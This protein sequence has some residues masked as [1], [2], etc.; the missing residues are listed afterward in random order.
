MVTG[1]SRW[2][3]ALL[4][5]TRRA[6]DL[7]AGWWHLISGLGAVPRTLVWD[8][9]GAVGRNR[10]GRVELTAECQGFRGVLGTKVIVLKPAEPEHKG[11]IERAHDYLETLVP[12]RPG[13]R[14]PRRLQHPAAGL[15]GP[16]QRPP[17][18]GAGLRADRP[19]RRGPGRD[20]AAAAGGSGHRVADLDPAGTRPLRAAGLQRLLGPSRRDRPP[21]RGGRRPGPGQGVQRRE[22]R[23]RPST[24]LGLAPDPDRPR[25]P[26][27]RQGAAPH[28][29]RGAAPGPRPGARARRS[30]SGRWPTTTPRSASIPT[31]SSHH[32]RT[33]RALHRRVVGNRSGPDRR[34]RLPDPGVE[35]AHPARGGA[36]AGRTRPRRSPGP[37]RSS[38][39]PACNARSPPG[40]PTAGRA[41]SAPP[42]SPRGSRLEEF[43]F[44]HA[45][46]TQTRH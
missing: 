8:G 11:I 24:G 2:L 20:A 9:E 34:G 32:D 14:R 36:P 3:S 31:A 39:S 40:S 37:T 6:E 17:P 30:S 16:G 43:D 18:A 23:G 33:A 25:P 41:G 21:D 10:R 45:R 29:G 5:P 4:V 13:L 44:D 46:G 28:P 1:Y 15:A 26:R 35:G 19:G 27:G 7:Y 22:D 38:W 12:A 42:G